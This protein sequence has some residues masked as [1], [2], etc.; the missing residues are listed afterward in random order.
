MYIEDIL[1]LILDCIP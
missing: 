1:S